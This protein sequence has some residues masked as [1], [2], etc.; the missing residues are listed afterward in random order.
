MSTLHLPGSIPNLHDCLVTRRLLTGGPPSPLK[1]PRH[2]GCFHLKPMQLQSFLI[3]RRTLALFLLTL[4]LS[5]QAWGAR[6]DVISETCVDLGTGK[7]VAALREVASG[8]KAKKLVVDPI[9]LETTLVSSTKLKCEKTTF[10]SDS[11][12]APSLYGRALTRFTTPSTGQFVSANE[13][14]KRFSPVCASQRSN[15]SLGSKSPLQPM[16]LTLDFCPAQSRGDEKHPHRPM[17][18]GYLE[19][20]RA[21]GQ[22]TGRTVNATIF[23]SGGWIRMHRAEV[24][25][26]IAFNDPSRGLSLTFAN[27]SNT[28]P[29]LGHDIPATQNFMTAMSR[30]DFVNEV[31]TTEKEMLKAGLTPSVFFRFPGL[32]SNATE[33]EALKELGLIPVGTTGWLALDGGR[34]TQYAGFDFSTDQAAKP[35]RILLTHGNGNEENGVRG[36]RGV[37]DFIL[38]HG[39]STTFVPLTTALACSLE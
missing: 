20:L 22:R 21:E 7:T 32:M 23:I 9:T 3:E 1:G 28:H 16:S 33:I 11:T 35:G 4:G 18:R 27:H 29:Y 25:E 34:N 31:L 36:H 10:A 37:L 14:L 19:S 26:L 15:L 24:K 39:A 17:D 13:G 2:R 12:L 38:Q 8:S 30:N 6:Y 5:G